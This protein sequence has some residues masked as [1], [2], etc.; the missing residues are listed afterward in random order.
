MFIPKLKIKTLAILVLFFAGISLMAQEKSEFKEKLKNLDG[1]VDKVTVKVD[2]KDVVFEGKDAEKLIQI[3]KPGEGKNI[4]IFSDDKD[5][6]TS[7]NKKRVKIIS[8]GN[9]NLS[10]SNEDFDWKDE[11]LKDNQKK[12]KVTID[13][14]KKVVTVTTVKDGKEETKTYEGED[15]DKFLKENETGKEFNIHVMKDGEDCN[16]DDLYF[17]TK[18]SSD[19][20]SC[21]CCKCDHK[22]MNMMKE[23]EANK[24]MMKKSDKDKDMKVIIK[25]KSDKEKEDK[26]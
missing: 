21:C 7:M 20:N 3:V 17:V 6:K 15:A 22:K 11:G 16:S 2:G 24:M 9:K 8:H 13:D 4:M 5:A 23:H 18:D 25:K 10:L 19:D 26:K 14:G 1:K 12:I